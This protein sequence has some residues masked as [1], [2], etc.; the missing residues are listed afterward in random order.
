[1]TERCI[2]RIDS[3]SDMTR[4]HLL[5][6]RGFF[7]AGQPVGTPLNPCGDTDPKPSDAMIEGEAALMYT[8]GRKKV[9]REA[10]ACDR[11]VEQTK[12]YKNKL[13]RRYCTYFAYHVYS[14]T[15]GSRTRMSSTSGTRL[16]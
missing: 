13:T 10:H 9:C 16:K 2:V 8:E 3:C 15:S 11:K 12:H 1:M 14:R 4:G 5:P 6:D 7:A